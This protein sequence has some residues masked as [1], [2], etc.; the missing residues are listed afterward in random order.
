[1]ALH[2]CFQPAFPLLPIPTPLQKLAPSPLPYIP[3]ILFSKQLP[4]VPWFND[5]CKRA[6]KERK[7]AQRKFFS[8]PTLSNVQNFKLLR[9]NRL[10]A[11]S[12]NNKR[13]SWRHFC[14]KINSKTQTEKV[15]KVIRKI[16]GKGGCNSVNHLKVNG[17]LITDEKEVTEVLAKNLSIFF[18]RIIILMNFRGLK[19]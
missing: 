3:K 13:N 2:P 7:K 5:S 8:N 12:N 14:N 19:C 9:A 17:N 15:W 11:L 4:K 1:M 6:I 18:R 10:V 16:K